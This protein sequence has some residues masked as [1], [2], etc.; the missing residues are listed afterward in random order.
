M[1]RLCGKL[2][3]PLP[4]LSE[5]RIERTPNGVALLTMSLPSVPIL[6]W[7]SGVP[8]TLREHSTEAISAPTAAAAPNVAIEAPVADAD[9][10][11]AT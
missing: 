6:L 3:V 5:K 8:V 9:Q 11:A 2:Q 10:A 4:R 1:I 7:P